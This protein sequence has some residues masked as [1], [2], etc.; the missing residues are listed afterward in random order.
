MPNSKGHKRAFGTVRKLPS[1]RYQA[2]YTTPDGRQVGA[3]RANGDPLTFETK[4]DAEGWL[5][6]RHSDVLRG[7][8]LPAPK[9]PTASFGE[10]ADAWL[11][12]RQ[13]APRTRELYRRLL[14]NHLKPRFGEVALSAISKPDVRA[15]HSGLKCGRTAKAHAYQL[16]RTVCG[17]AVV[18]D[19]I[20]SNPCQI[21]GAGQ[22]KRAR[23]ITIP[24][25]AEVA[26]ITEAMPAGWRLMVTLAATCG[27]RF[28]EA[29]ELRRGDV[30]PRS[31]VLRIRRGV[32]RITGERVVGSPKSAAGVRD[33]AIPPHVLPAV[34]AHLKEHVGSGRDA[35]L[36]PSDAGVQLN[37]STFR[38]HWYAARA[39]AGR[40]DLRF[41]D[42]RHAA[43]MAAAAAGADLP[44]L[45]ARMG[46][47]SPGAALV[48][49]H[50]AADRDRQIAKRMSELA[51]VA[52]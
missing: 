48:Y 41:H 38:R 39:A 7:E 42:L 1:G 4:T 45:M 19:L 29:T 24:T 51:A 28:G 26:T 40:T 8:W 25:S 34:R 5:S 10:Y 30:D 36:F 22:T 18:D 27:V 11:A 52:G 32:T 35:L 44:Q 12:G 6:L 37:E 23:K 49:L 16:L 47:S 3:K 46:H 20:A 43:N 14:T 2:R 15:W 33:V 13:L 50:T 9:A 21:R 17:T 31:D